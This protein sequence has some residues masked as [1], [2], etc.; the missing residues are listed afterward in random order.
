MPPQQGEGLLDFLGGAFNFRAHAGGISLKVQKSI[1]ALR[2][3]APRP[4]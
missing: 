1:L 3:R 4:N 2:L